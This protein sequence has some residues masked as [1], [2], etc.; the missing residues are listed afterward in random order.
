ML[1]G[2]LDQQSVL[3]PVD[4]RRLPGRA[5]HHNAVGALAHVEV[6]QAPEPLE[7]QTAVFMHRGDDR[8]QAAGKHMH[9]SA[10]GIGNFSATFWCAGNTYKS[11]GCRTRR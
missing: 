9:A 1:D 7:I 4:G 3:V 11:P 8:D 10:L 2:S 6:D 5:Y